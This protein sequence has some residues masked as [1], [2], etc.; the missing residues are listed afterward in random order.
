MV[1]VVPTE[2]GPN[3]F[4]TI[5]FLFSQNNYR[6]LRHLVQGSLEFAAIN[7]LTNK[8]S[9]GKYIFSQF[10]MVQNAYFS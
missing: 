9:L 1:W 10:Y 5:H 2:N 3:K 4:V 7:Y 8:N 6:N